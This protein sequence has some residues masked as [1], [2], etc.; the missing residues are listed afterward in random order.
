MICFQKRV[1]RS[2]E[3]A[4]LLPADHHHRFALSESR[5]PRECLFRHA[6]IPT[7]ALQQVG[8]FFPRSLE[9]QRLFRSRTA[10]IHARRRAGIK[11]R[12]CIAG[13]HRLPRPRKSGKI[14]VR[15]GKNFRHAYLSNLSFWT[16]RALRTCARASRIS[17]DIGHDGRRPPLVFFYYG[18]P[19]AVRMVRHCRSGDRQRRLIFSFPLSGFIPQPSPHPHPYF[20]STTVLPKS[21][22]LRPPS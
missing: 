20:S 13:R 19:L 12:R 4:H 17:L 14:R 22:L 7:A 6:V 18:R 16:P 1:Q 21:S 11:I 2:A 3:I 9:S 15:Y 5:K 10:R 8:Q